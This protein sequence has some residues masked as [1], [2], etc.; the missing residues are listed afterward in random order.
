VEKQVEL[1]KKLSL[2]QIKQL[3]AEIHV[4]QFVEQTPQVVM[5]V[6]LYA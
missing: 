5:F 4:V 6:V 3:V 1:Y 2:S